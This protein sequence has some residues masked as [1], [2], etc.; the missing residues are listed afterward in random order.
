VAW[1]YNS[2]R[3]LLNTREGRAAIERFGL[4]PFIDG[5]C[6]REPDFQSEFPSISGLRCFVFVS[7]DVLRSRSP[8]SST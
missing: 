5:S 4:P 1:F 8:G 3:P 6:R 2:F 7:R